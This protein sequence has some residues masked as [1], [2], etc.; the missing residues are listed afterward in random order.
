MRF[1]LLA[2]ALLSGL[3]VSLGF[4]NTALAN[5]KGGTI[6]MVGSSTNHDYEVT[7]TY[8]TDKEG[9]QS[10]QITIVVDGNEPGTTHK[11]KHIS[12]TCDDL[13]ATWGE[14]GGG[15]TITFGPI[16]DP[17]GNLTPGGGQGQVPLKKK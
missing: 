11:F 1:A 13:E 14:D 16:G 12:F 4:S 9:N 15:I 8:S 7:V 17:S 10:G 5:N 3:F 6:T 2:L